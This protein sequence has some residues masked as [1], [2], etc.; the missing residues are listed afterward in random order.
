MEVAE[1]LV[2]W[3]AL[4]NKHALI[5]LSACSLTSG[6]VPT[7]VFIGIQDPNQTSQEQFYVFAL[8]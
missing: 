6:P 5:Q 1:W 4:K 8:K 3:A 2:H 7:T